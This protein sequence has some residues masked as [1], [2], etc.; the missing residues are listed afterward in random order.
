MMI[1]TPS[2]N[3]CSQKTFM[4]HLWSGTLY[5]PL[6]YA[7]NK[8][9]KSDCGCRHVCVTC[10]PKRIEQLGSNWTDFYE[11]WYLRNF[12]KYFGENSI[13]INI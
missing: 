6:A 12:Q 2:S 5:H 13:L 10:Q 8:I 11:I 7:F 1:F 3:P 9:A 4:L